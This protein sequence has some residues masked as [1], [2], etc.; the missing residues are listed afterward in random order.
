MSRVPYV[1]FNQDYY[2][3]FTICGIDLALNDYG[4]WDPS[5]FA[6]ALGQAEEYLWDH[7]DGN[8]AEYD[9]YFELLSGEYPIFYWSTEGGSIG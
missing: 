8:E 5:D 6:N 9:S 7:Y 3:L 4:G 1:P 2:D